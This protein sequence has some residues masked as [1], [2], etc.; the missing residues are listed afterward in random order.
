[1]LLAI[2]IGN[3]NIV[4]GLLEL[5]NGSKKKS[6]EGEKKLIH[7]WRLSTFHDR[8]ADEYSTLITSLFHQ[9][10]ISPKHVKGVALSCVVP[11]LQNPFVSV[12]HTLFGVNP[13]VIGPGTKTGMS[14]LYDN[15]KEVGA[16]RIV[17]AIAAY[18]RFKKACIIVDFGTATTFDLVNSEGQYAGGVIAPGIAISAEALF[19]R[20]S[21]LPR[22]DVVAP[23]RVIG[24]NTVSSMQ[25]GLY[26]GYLGLVDRIVKEILKEGKYIKN[27][28]KILATGGF[29]PLLI[30]D[31]ELIETIIPHL[32]LEGLEI[33]YHMNQKPKS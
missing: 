16:D 10:D 20:A 15:P 33:V 26:Y 23:N 7:C 11:P 2:D 21:K 24:K 12:I 3:T 18:H 22:V 19:Q 13:V 4:L 17:N 14:I 5:P 30:Q 28:V 29:A 6:L 31:S 8:T 27:D 9:A 32:T 25:S 1:M